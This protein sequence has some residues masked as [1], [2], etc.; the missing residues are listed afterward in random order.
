MSGTRDEPPK[1]LIAK[2]TPDMRRNEPR[3]IGVIVWCAGNCAAKFLGESGNRITAPKFIQSKNAFRQWLDYW[4]EVIG[5]DSI[6]GDDG[7]M[8]NRKQEKWL[9]ALRQT[10]KGNYWLE[11]SGELLDVVSPEEL[12]SV[13]DFLFDELVR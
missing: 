9:D 2:Y 13:A 5:K 4:R 10:S 11:R 12:Q 6:R 7:R 8:V 1:F 3:N